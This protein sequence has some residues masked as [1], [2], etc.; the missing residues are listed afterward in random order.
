MSIH[1]EY[2]A[3]RIAKTQNA[4]TNK[5]IEETEAQLTK[6]YLNSMKRVI[7]QF[8]D[9]Y[10]HY[11]SRLAKG[12]EPTPADLYKL[13]AYWQMQ[14]QLKK[15]LQ[16]LGNKEV[17]LLS[18][19]FFDEFN[20]IYEAIAIKTNLSF[21][22]ISEQAAQQ[23]IN[24]IWCADGKSWSSRVW[25]NLD[26]LQQALNDNLIDCVITGKKSSE[27]KRLLI[28]EFKVA[29]NRADTIVRTELA[30]IQTQAA[31]QRYL[32]SGISEVEVLADKDERRCEECGRLHKKR[33][34]IN[35]A[36]PVPVHANC[37]C[38]IIPVVE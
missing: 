24:Q 16:K 38:C 26:K 5:T 8:E 36:M 22:K 21:G 33:F 2:W 3:R 35:G 15:E 4:L 19:N 37:R 32:D 14:G 20:Q 10:N 25:T 29:Y 6:Y 9:T 31:R 7:K 34:P 12:V 28:D 27:L 13:D 30:H 18:K 23:I 11:L 1:D 17:E